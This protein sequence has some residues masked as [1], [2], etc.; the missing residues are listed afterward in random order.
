LL[1][2]PRA[3]LLRVPRSTGRRRRH[4]MWFSRRQSIPEF[5][6]LPEY[7]R[8]ARCWCA[9]HAAQTQFLDVDDPAILADL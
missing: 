3:A 5:L 1:A 8:G 9:R 4:P 2:G 7:R 6:A